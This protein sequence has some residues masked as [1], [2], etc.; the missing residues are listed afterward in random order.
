MLPPILRSRITLYVK[1]TNTFIE[2]RMTLVSDKEISQC[3]DECH[4]RFK[5][6]LFYLDLA[7]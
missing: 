2:F 1:F 5:A 4:C 3:E 7:S 6:F